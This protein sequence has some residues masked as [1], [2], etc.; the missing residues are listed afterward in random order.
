MANHSSK[1]VGTFAYDL[2]FYTGAESLLN[3]PYGLLLSL[4]VVQCPYA[5]FFQ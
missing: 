2:L 5:L 3:R 1:T 4:F